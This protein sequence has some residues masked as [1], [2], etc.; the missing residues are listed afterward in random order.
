MVNP[1]HVVILTQGV[2]VWNEWRLKR[3]DALESSGKCK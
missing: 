3:R 2:A 1:E